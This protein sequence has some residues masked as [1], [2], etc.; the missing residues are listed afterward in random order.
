VIDGFT[1]QVLRADSR[2]IH[3]LLVEK[4]KAKEPSDARPAARRR[5]RRARSR[6]G[7][8]CRRR[9]RGL[10]LGFAPFYA[11]PVPIARLAAFCTSGPQRLAAA[12]RHSP[13]TRSGWATSSRA[14]RG[15][16]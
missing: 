10:R 7:C 16:T 15:F 5:A 8:C 13:A 3:A 9:G 2:K 12:R 6:R 1:F 11:W 4:P 14:C